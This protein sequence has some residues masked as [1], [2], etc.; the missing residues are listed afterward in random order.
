METKG[1]FLLLRDGANGPKATV[2]C[3]GCPCEF[4]VFPSV[5]N[6]KKLLSVQEFRDHVRQLHEQMKI[7]EPKVGE[8]VWTWGEQAFVRYRVLNVV[9]GIADLEEESLP[10]VTKRMPWDR[11]CYEE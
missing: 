10:R 6:L 3:S 5:P 1:V 4:H 8:E 2:K 9:D 11:L 7:R